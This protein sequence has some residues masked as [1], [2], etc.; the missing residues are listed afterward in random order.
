MLLLNAP[1]GLPERIAYHIFGNGERERHMARI[2]S[3]ACPSSRF[4]GYIETVPEKADSFVVFTGADFVRFLAPLSAGQKEKAI[5]MPVPIGDP[6]GYFEVLDLFMDK[7]DGDGRIDVSDWREVL[8]RLGL[9]ARD[10]GWRRLCW[11][12]Q[13]HL[14]LPLLTRKFMPT[15]VRRCFPSIEHTLGES[16]DFSITSHYYGYNYRAL[17]NANYTSINEVRSRLSNEE[18]RNAY[19]N[20]LRGDPDMMWD[21]YLGRLLGSQQYF[22][23]LEI[24]QDDVIL[25]GGVF[26]GTEVPFFIM[27]AGDG[28]QIHNIDPL[29]HDH[30]SDYA[31]ESISVSPGAVFEHRCALSDR[32][33]TIELID[34]QD[35]QLRMLSAFN[36]P[37]QQYPC[38]TLMTFIERNKLPKVDLIK[39]DIEGGK[40][41]LLESL[42]DVVG[43]YRPQIAI[44]IYHKA[45]DLWDIPLRL[46]GVCRD[47]NFY[48]SVYGVDHNDGVLY[49]VP[50]E[51]NARKKEVR[52]GLKYRP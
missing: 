22:E 33:G 3:L 50:S 4:L 8:I 24:R 20:M 37:R 27:Y 44:S 19:M 7:I 36:R 34:D 12:G 10:K 28:G 52:I 14:G 18:S 31:R 9:A 41:L 47:Y 43:K 35:G 13:T 32:D 16:A 30:L 49:C 21:H 5:V 48:F 23:Y 15:G 2:L 39:L 26:S 17:I 1:S 38:F 29:G 42:A 25:N 45:T 51:R 6:L 11:H 46:F 40:E